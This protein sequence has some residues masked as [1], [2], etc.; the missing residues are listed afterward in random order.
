[1]T[2]SLA[3]LSQFQCRIL[4]E[5]EKV[6]GTSKA[7]FDLTCE[8]VHQIMIS[9]IVKPDLKQWYADQGSK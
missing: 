9:D 6:I 3:E 4:D 1:M 8:I 7:S 5:V 2:P